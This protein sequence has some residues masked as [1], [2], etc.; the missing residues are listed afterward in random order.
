MTEV[1][2]RS[3]SA[4]PRRHA[5]AAHDAPPGHRPR[6]LFFQWDHSPNRGLSDYF[7]THMNDHV[8][9]LA[10]HFDVTVVNHDCDYGEMCD[11]YR[12]EVTLFESGYQ[13]F[14]S[15]RPT[16]V[17]VRGNDHVPR[18]GLH[19]AD[20]WSDCRS[21]FLSDMDTWGIDVFFSICATTT[22]Y[23]PAVSDRMFIWPNFIDPEVFRDYGYKKLVPVTICG[24]R[25]ES[26][27]W[28]E[29]VFPLLERM[30]PAIVCP[31]FHNGS[32]LGNRTL[33]GEAYARALNAA[34]FSPTCGTVAGE[35]V[36]KHLEIPG[37]GACLITQ[38]SAALREAGFIHME[39]CVFCEPDT[40]VEAIDDLLAD[41]DR[42]RRITESG[43]R[44]VHARHTF[45]HRP[46]I[47]QWFQL[48]RRLE[49]GKRIVQG[50]P[51]A[52][53]EIARKPARPAP[54]F[55]SRGTHMSALRRAE[56]DL[57][58][59]RTKAARRGFQDCLEYVKYLPEARF[60]LALCD[61][62]DGRP[63]KAG[64]T[65]AGLIERTVE[66]YGARD[67]DP[68]EWVYFIVSVLAR[69]DLER[70]GRLARWYPAVA[71]RERRRLEAALR[72]AGLHCKANGTADRSD[73]PSIHHPP[74]RDDEA[75]AAWLADVLRRSGQP[76]LARHV[77][78]CD[79]DAADVARASPQTRSRH[80][81]GGDRLLR[82]LDQ[83]LRLPG[84]SDLRPRVPPAPEFQY[85]GCLVRNA[86]SK[87]AG[88]A[89]LVGLRKMWRR[90]RAKK[91]AR[92]I[93]QTIRTQGPMTRTL[94]E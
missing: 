74:Q 63:E 47:F 3:E 84:L 66:S 45:R 46:Q 57:Q 51:F 94:G 18:L 15:R 24:Q 32:R 65:L 73:R 79:G 16:I 90:L 38:N 87:I 89:P 2:T 35:V 20:A 27:P 81:T 29:K 4:T 30:F 93:R 52:D 77:A 5:P 19:N 13:T 92:W 44:L 1:G 53:L 60:G 50:G 76:D 31:T 72:R 33:S 80:I 22:E 55:V 6:L 61:L 28:R 67:P 43:H 42:L 37:A 48:H 34:F 83:A 70:A 49:A 59:G 58:A 69:G 86:R 11:R 14:A 8:R 88:S 10:E 25:H 68:V 39:N 12:P 54:I 75:W 62:Q 26:Y 78:P 56:E 82:G 41:H 9:C 64:T 71:H 17:N 40:V 36:R 21:G 7:V 23:M 91:E 85:F